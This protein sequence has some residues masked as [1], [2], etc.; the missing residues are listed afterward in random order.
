VDYKPIV[1]I[2]ST[3]HKLS[4]DW[5]Y[6]HLGCCDAATRTFNNHSFEK[7]SSWQQLIQI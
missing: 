2:P 6:L 7:L 1:K 5:N 3:S 4:I